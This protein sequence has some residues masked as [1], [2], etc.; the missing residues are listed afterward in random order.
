VAKTPPEAGGTMS[1]H[2]TA[3]KREVLHLVK[4]E[5]AAIF[6]QLTPKQERFVESYL[7]ED[8]IKVAARE[9]GISERTARRW[10]ADP[11]LQ[12]AIA[13]LRQERREIRE[14]RLAVCMNRAI[15]IVADTLLYASDESEAKRTGHYVDHDREFKY[16]ALMFKYA[17]NQ[18]EI[19]AL[20]LRIVQLETE[21][22]KNAIVGY[23]VSID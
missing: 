9:A 10:L 6:G 22:A 4:T 8:F 7:D 21:L 12:A 14:N 17:Y 16:V 15:D 20:K 13:Q 19:D 23:T 5:K 1:A 11:A 2:S 18:R 3:T